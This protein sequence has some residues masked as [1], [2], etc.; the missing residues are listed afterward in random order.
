MPSEEDLLTAMDRYTRWFDGKLAR[1]DGQDLDPTINNIK[2][3]EYESSLYKHPLKID[4]HLRGFGF[5][6]LY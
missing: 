4:E 6:T 3:I 1:R 2:I 5:W